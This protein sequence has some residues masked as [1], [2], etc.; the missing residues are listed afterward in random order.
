MCLCEELSSLSVVVYRSHKNSQKLTIISS[1]TFCC[2][3]ESSRISDPSPW[4]FDRQGLIL[5]FP[6][7]S[8]CFVGCGAFL[9]V[10]SKLSVNT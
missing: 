9:L 7:E 4:N 5:I 2:Q 6:H 1:V 10:F 3:E 8:K